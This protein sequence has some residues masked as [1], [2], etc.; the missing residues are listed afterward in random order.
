MSF[1]DDDL[2]QEPVEAPDTFVPPIRRWRRF[3]PLGSWPT[4]AAR[5]RRRLAAA[6]APDQGAH[7]AGVAGHRRADPDQHRQ[8]MPARQGR[9]VRTTRYL[10]SSNAIA[11]ESQ[12][13]A[14]QLADTARQQG[15][16]EAGR[17]H[18]T[19]RLIW[20][21]SRPV[22][23][24]A[25][26]SSSAPDRLSAPNRTL[27]TAL[28]YRAQGSRQLP[29]AIDGRGHREGQSPQRQRRWPH[30]CRCWRRA[31]SSTARRTRC[32]PK[33][34]SQQDKIKDVQVAKSE[35]FP[36]STYD[37][38]S[39]AGAVKVIANIKQARVSTD[40]VTGCPTA[41]PPTG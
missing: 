12:D 37:K 31:T 4:V 36:G 22:L 9:R 39:P 6:A 10:T 38:T 29:A 17:D 21:P 11:G 18:G 23:S 5:W 3:G 34:R 40:P 24:S 19:G 20:P 35:F 32:R 2:F 13:S 16:A 1:A 15:A 25:P 14:R 28:E 27:V 7:R 26:R 8:G 41:A 30:R 33:T